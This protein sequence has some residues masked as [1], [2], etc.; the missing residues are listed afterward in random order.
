MSTYPDFLGE[1]ASV[2]QDLRGRSPTAARRLVALT[3]D[4]ALARSLEELAGGGVDVCVVADTESLSE[5]LLQSNSSIAL[6]DANGLTSPIEAIV[7][8]LAIQFPDLRL[9]VAGHSGEQNQLATRIANGRVFRFVHKPASAQRLKLMIDATSRPADPNRVSVTQTLHVLPEPRKPQ[10]AKL[11]DAIRGRTPPMLGIGLGIVA[12][13]ALGAFLL[14]PEGDPAPAAVSPQRSAASASA[15]A[16]SAAAELMRKA[17]QAFAAGV[18]VA[19]DGSSAAELYRD[20]LKV[21]AGDARAKSGFERSIDLGLRGAEQALVENRLD[22]AAGAAETL[23]LLSPS[24]SRLAF[25]KGQIDKELSRANADA[26]QRAA[27]DA[28]QAQIRKNLGDMNERLRRGALLEPTRDNA[29]VHFRAAEAAGPGDMAVRN[30]RDSL[31]AAL[32]NAS[33]AEID[34]DR[35]PAAR[36]LL[37]A[38]A[39]INSGAP[40]LDP[41][42]RRLEEMGTRAAPAVVAAPLEPA[43]APAR[44]PEPATVAAAAPPPEVVQESVLRRLQSVEPEYP[45]RALNQLISGWVDLEFTVAANG[46]VRDITVMASEPRNTFN[47][48]AIAAL[49]RWRY[50][51]V[52]RNGEAVSQRARV[53][54]RFTARDQD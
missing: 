7:D 33:D 35:A 3:L 27:F 31:V 39:S 24:N 30:A 53:R 43:A 45:E 22:A 6:I 37:D 48:A 16:P 51:P 25:L 2:A 41:L 34:A 38:A 1:E 49:R 11:D 15:S 14:W 26:S 32:L 54:I 9:L 23:R 18:Y 21:D 40:G 12:A 5:E 42:R 36:R 28:R 4:D 17:D 47:A 50:A 46:S 20:A 19:A 10:L 52:L 44:D 8:A 13:I 29:M